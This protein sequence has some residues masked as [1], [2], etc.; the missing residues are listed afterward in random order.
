MADSLVNTFPVLGV[1]RPFL[2]SVLRGG[3][4]FLPTTTPTLGDFGILPSP[5]ALTGFAD[6]I[7]RA[8]AD[9]AEWYPPLVNLLY[10][11]GFARGDAFHDT[12]RRLVA[13][14]LDRPLTD[15]VTMGELP[16]HLT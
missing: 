15:E 16:M 12:I 13:A 8:F 11:G 2:E 3:L 14:K 10:Q 4:G 7:W 1:D 9:A 6:T 5:A